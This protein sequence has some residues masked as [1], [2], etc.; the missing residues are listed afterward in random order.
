VSPG[1]ASELTEVRISR[2]VPWISGDVYSLQDTIVANKRS[3][4]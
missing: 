4:M 2:R 3:V 1:S